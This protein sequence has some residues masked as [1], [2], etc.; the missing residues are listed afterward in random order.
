MVQIVAFHDEELGAWAPG[1]GVFALYGSPP[2]RANRGGGKGEDVGR[3]VV[4][5]ALDT[6][7]VLTHIDAAA[8]GVSICLP[9][10]HT[11]GT[12]SRRS[13]APPP[14]WCCPDSACM[15]SQTL[16]ILARCSS[17]GLLP[18]K[19]WP[20]FV[21]APD[22]EQAKSVFDSVR[23]LR[24]MACLCPTAQ[25]RLAC[26]LGATWLLEEQRAARL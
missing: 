16:R 11:H 8:E 18:E 24:T 23:G 3:R 5:V 26:S 4:E 2:L 20:S 1:V 10:V 13:S 25:K 17:S 21:D 19:C 12:N 9:S 22:H 15:A 7:Q 6:C 14:P